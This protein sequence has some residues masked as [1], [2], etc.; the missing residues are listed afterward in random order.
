MLTVVFLL[1]YV[2]PLAL[3]G[4]LIWRFVLKP[5]TRATMARIDQETES[6]NLRKRIEEDFAVQDDPARGAT[7]EEEFEKAIK[8]LKDNP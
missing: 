6:A 4:F 3:I 5:I 8:E 7:A 1:Q 2:I